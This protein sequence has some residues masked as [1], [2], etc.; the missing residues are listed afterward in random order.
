MGAY[1]FLTTINPEL[2]L[3]GVEE[4]EA[5]SLVGAFGSIT[6][7]DGANCDETAPKIDLYDD[8]T[9]ED[10]PGWEDKAVSFKITKGLI[11]RICSDKDYGNC[12][13]YIGGD[14]TVPPAE[15]PDGNTCFQA[16]PRFPPGEGAGISSVKGEGTV[17][18]VRLILFTSA[19]CGGNS[20]VFSDSIQCKAVEGQQWK[21]NSY[22][23]LQDTVS[24]SLPVNYETLL[25]DER[26]WNDCSNEI[27]PGSANTCNNR[28]DIRSVCVYKEDS[29]ESC[30]GAFVI[31]GARDFVPYLRPSCKNLSSADP[32]DVYV[33]FVGDNCRVTL[34]EALDCGTADSITPKGDNWDRRPASDDFFE[35]KYGSALGGVIGF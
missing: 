15:D 1:I 18:F 4:A 34:N 35:D 9:L 27:G 28:A 19:D 12:E 6:L 17:D 32:T 5:P 29:P 33:R 20:Q 10:N 25:C 31:N 24:S 13:I 16:G 26:N 3:F 30:V 22:W 2:I 8:N 21:G 11:A 14:K 23:L 7:Y